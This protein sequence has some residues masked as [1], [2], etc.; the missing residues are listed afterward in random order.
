MTQTKQIPMP[1]FGK[2]LRC[3]ATGRLFTVVSKRKPKNGYLGGVKVVHLTAGA[4][5]QS[6][7]A[8]LIGQ[9]FEEVE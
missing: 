3:R 5:H 9:L 7:R 1:A 6:V 2:A 8:D 4:T